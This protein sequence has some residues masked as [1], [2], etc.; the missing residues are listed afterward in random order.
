[1]I[2]TIRKV[3]VACLAVFGGAMQE[4]Q[5]HL[6]SA[7]VM[8]LLLLQTQ[9]NPYLEDRK[10]LQTLEILSLVTTWL[11]LWTGTIFY[12]YPKCEGSAYQQLAWCNGIS[13]LI[14]MFNVIILF[15]MI[16]FFL[17]FKRESRKQDA[18]KS[19]S[20]TKIAVAPTLEAPSRSDYVNG[21]RT[22]TAVGE[23]SAGAG[24]A[25]KTSSPLPTE[26]QTPSELAPSK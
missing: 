24:G 2:V 23:V 16:V 18:Q 8:G 17:R 15:V 1:M 5:V 9:M 6:S 4:M 26:R 20:K 11:T 21:L 12:S 10:I 14:G 25:E 19:K 13:V 7:L 3:S 22:W